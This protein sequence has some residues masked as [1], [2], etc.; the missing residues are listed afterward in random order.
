MTDTNILPSSKYAIQ[1]TNGEVITSLMTNNSYT[2]GAKSARVILV[3]FTHVKMF[4][5]INLQ[6]KF[7]NL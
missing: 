2:I 4:G 6:L 5:K 7:E 3:S 1:P